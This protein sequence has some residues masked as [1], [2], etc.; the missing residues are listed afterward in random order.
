MHF[1]AC[2]KEYEAMLAF[3]GLSGAGLVVDAGCGSGGFMR[4]F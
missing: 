2:R 4:P 3:G 1:E